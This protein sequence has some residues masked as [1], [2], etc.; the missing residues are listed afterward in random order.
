MKALFCT[1]AAALLACLPVTADPHPRAGEF[2]TWK[3][4]MFLH[5]NM[6]T[7]IDREWANGHEDPALFNPGGLDCN[8][9]AE[10]AKNA[11]MKYAVLTVKHTGG[12]CLWDSKLTTHD[13]TAFKNFREGK[14]DLVAEFVQ[15]CRKHGLKVGLYYC[16]PGDYVGK[17][18]PPL[19]AGQTDLHGLPPEAGNDRT[20]FVKQQ[21]TELLTRYGPI[22][23]LWFDQFDNPYTGRD[24]P[25][26][27]DHAHKLQ[28][29]CL[30]LANNCLDP[31]QTDIASYEY[32]YLRLYHPNRALPLENSTMPA[33][34][35]DVLGPAWFWKTTETAE[36]LAPAQAIADRL[37]LCNA[38]NANYLLNV[39]PDKTGRIPAASVERLREIARLAGLAPTE[40]PVSPGAL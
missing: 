2:L 15:A 35:C 31:A 11:G 4:G 40:T 1:I 20:S 10:T 14:G 32:P 25:Q 29:D 28:P 8:Q 30:V 18:S 5:F 9:W 16:M 39:A 33:E 6:A 38:R 19:Q 17:N 26:I 7:Y 13:V 34:V 36:T 12:W 22:D 27:L 23:L 24:W 21:I 37:K 3:Y